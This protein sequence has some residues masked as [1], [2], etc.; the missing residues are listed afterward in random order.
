MNPFRRTTSGRERVSALAE[1][2]IVSMA[3]A[4]VELPAEAT[5]E[6]LWTLGIA[7]AGWWLRG[8][9]EV[10]SVLRETP[11]LPV[12]FAV[13][14]SVKALPLFAATAARATDYVGLSRGSAEF[15]NVVKELGVAKLQTALGNVLFGRLQTQVLSAF[16]SPPDLAET[17]SPKP[18]PAPGLGVPISSREAAG[19]AVSQAV[20]KPVDAPT[21]GETPNVSAP[22]MALLRTLYREDDIRRILK[23]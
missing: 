19:T 23:G 4:K 10:D 7:V 2:L 14:G 8:D 6:A 11:L 16:H 12:L 17:V 13:F 9:P 3:G 21:S 15:A 22:T 1:R 20:G 5:P 18:K